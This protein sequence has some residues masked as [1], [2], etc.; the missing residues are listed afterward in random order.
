VSSAAVSSVTLQTPSGLAAGDLLL[1]VLTPD[2]NPTVSAPPG[3]TLVVGPLK[4]DGG[5][6]VFAYY[7]VVQAG[8]SA[9]NYAWALGSPQKWGGGITAYRGV[10]TSHPLDVGT[11]A[12]KV[13][14]TGTSTSITLSGVTTA[15]SGAMLIGGLGADGSTANTNPPTGWTEAFDSLGGQMSEHAYW[16]QG[17]AG[18][19]GAATWT[20]DSARAMAVWMSALRPAP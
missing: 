17:A 13:D 5:A 14:G 10:D 18:S 8:E 12:T 6:E 19:S 7:H 3:W 15:T 4:P 11:P 16:L 9:A 1:A 20:L 2:N